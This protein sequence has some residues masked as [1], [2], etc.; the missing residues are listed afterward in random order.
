MPGLYLSFAQ[1]LFSDHDEVGLVAQ[2]DLC[3]RVGFDDLQ[4]STQTANLDKRV[5]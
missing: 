3:D 4:P 2:R 1:R 5:G